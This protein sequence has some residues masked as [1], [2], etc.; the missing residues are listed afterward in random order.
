MGLRRY[1]LTGDSTQRE[2]V[3]W[4]RAGAPPGSRVVAAHQQS[5]MG[6]LDHSWDSPPG[7]LYMSVVTSDP[8]ASASLVPLAVGVGLRH[9]FEETYGVSPQ[10][11]WPNDLMIPRSDGRA[12]KLSGILVDRVGV[13]TSTSRLVVGVGVN[14]NASPASFDPVL[15]ESVVGLAELTLRPIDLVELEERVAAVV[16]AAVG[17]LTRPEGARSVVEQV[18]RALYGLGRLARV[19]GEPVW[20]VRGVADD[21]SLEVE[22]AGRVERVTTGS[23]SVEE[24]A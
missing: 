8:D 4:A 11:R 9:F 1:H 16:P 3:E 6:R 24:S 10:V 17:R 22:A 19:D 21:G 14:V 18:E 12:R 5:G 15:R 2:A 23:L 20:V 13:D 7:G